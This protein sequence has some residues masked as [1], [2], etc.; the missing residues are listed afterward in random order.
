MK[1]LNCEARSL[2]RLSSKSSCEKST[3][4]LS[5]IEI[6]SRGRSRC[7]KKMTLLGQRVNHLRQHRTVSYQREFSK[8][9]TCRH[10]V[11]LYTTLYE[12]DTILFR[13]TFQQ[14]MFSQLIYLPTSIIGCNIA[15]DFAESN[16]VSLQFDF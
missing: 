7:P 8:R 4:R 6:I 3:T 14:S 5:W 12:I 15:K 1:R 10:S 13:T 11:F 9:S 2:C 16:L